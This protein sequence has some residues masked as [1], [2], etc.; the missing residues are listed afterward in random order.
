M[1]L[2]L[3]AA[4]GVLP[5]SAARELGEHPA[6][7]GAWSLPALGAAIALAAAGCGAGVL[8]ATRCT[9]AV[10]QLWADTSRAIRGLTIRIT[11]VMPGHVLA[12]IAAPPRDALHDTTGREMDLAVGR[13]GLRGFRL[14]GTERGVTR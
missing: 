1:D 11:A 6:L 5:S 13:G 4:F 8:R 12:V 2:L 7:V 9:P 3:L 10:G 14:I